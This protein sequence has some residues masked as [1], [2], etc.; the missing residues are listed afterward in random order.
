MEEEHWHEQ[1]LRHP[2]FWLPWRLSYLRHLSYLIHF[3]FHSHVLYLFPRS[4]ND[5]GAM[6]VKLIFF[7]IVLGQVFN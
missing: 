3:Y 5:S 6:T 7:A 4:G 1:K 2:D